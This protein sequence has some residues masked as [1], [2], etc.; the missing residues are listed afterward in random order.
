MGVHGQMDGG[1]AVFWIFTSIFF[2]DFGSK[3]FPPMTDDSL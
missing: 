1:R 2:A 3:N